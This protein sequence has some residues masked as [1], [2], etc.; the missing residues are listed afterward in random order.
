MVWVSSKTSNIHQQIE[1]LKKHEYDV[2]VCTTVLER[3]MTVANV[4]VLILYG[5]HLLFDK[6]TLIQIAGRAGRKPPYIQGDVLIY[7]AKKTLAMKACIENIKT[8]NALSAT[9]S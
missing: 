6:E 1:K 9:K 8:D 5:E 2:L 7:A 3:G 4:Q